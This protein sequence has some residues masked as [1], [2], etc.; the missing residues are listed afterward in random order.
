[1]RIEEG[2]I[3]FRGHETWFRSVGDGPG[4]PLLCLHGGPGSTHLGLTPLEQLADE[5][6]VVLYDQLGS[7][8]SSKPSDPSLWTV[9]LFLAELANVRDALGLDR[10]HL[11]GHSWG[12]MLAQEYALT[13]PDGLASLV[14]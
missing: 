4:A 9:D 12:G 1:M 11:L 7:G 2:R 8:N 14:L 10:V 3:P 6:R 13:Q 5:R